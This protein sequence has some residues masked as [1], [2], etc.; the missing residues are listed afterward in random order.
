MASIRVGLKEF[1][2]N[3]TNSPSIKILNAK[4][5]NA[6]AGLIEG[7]DKADVKRKLTPVVKPDGK[8]NRGTQ[9]T[10][11]IENAY[12][13]TDVVATKSAPD[14]TK[15]DLLCEEPTSSFWRGMAEKLEKEIDDGLETSFNMS[16]E[17]DKSYE[18]LSESRNRLKVLMDV[19]DDIL[20]EVNDKEGNEDKCKENNEASNS[21]IV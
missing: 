14:I 9:V 16:L 21:A 6:T 17:L 5:T 19:M 15:E 4:K 2:S 18:E 20:S 8:E 11:P 3:S 13:Q 12:A 1:S 10:V 7:K